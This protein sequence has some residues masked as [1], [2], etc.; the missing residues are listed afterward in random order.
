MTELGDIIISMYIKVIIGAG[1]HMKTL[2]FK[3][4][5]NLRIHQPLDP[6]HGCHGLR[7]LG[8][9]QGLGLH[10]ADLKD[11]QQPPWGGDGNNG[12]QSA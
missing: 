7:P 3:N 12:E 4:F 9:G 1:D 2:H 8:V 5:S 6:R 10:H 11:S